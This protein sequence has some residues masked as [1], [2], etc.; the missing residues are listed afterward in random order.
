M[1]SPCSIIL[2]IDRAHIV[3]LSMGGYATLQ[4][5]LT[6]PQRALSLVI[7]GCGSGSERHYIEEFRKGSRATA[8]AFEQHGAAEAARTYGHGPGRIPF[9]VK[10][11]RGFAEFIAHFSEH[12]P[13]G[14]AH[15]LR[16]FQAG[17]P[18]LY[19]FEAEIRRCAVPSLIVVGDEDDVCIEPSIYLKSWLP[20]SGLAMFPKTGH[21]VNLEEPD[22]F[23]RTISD[24]IARVEAGRWPARDPRSRRA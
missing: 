11:P 21:G 20:A 18:S 23:N 6:H 4:V 7:A 9:L 12:D 10:D 2:S 22:L 16:G 3:G 24:F 5:G 1:R 8:D 17:R 14:S 13:K 19:D 15:T